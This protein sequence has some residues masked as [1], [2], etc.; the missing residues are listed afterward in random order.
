MKRTLAALGVVLAL[1]IGLSACNPRTAVNDA[2]AR[3]FPGTLT[4][5][6]TRVARCESGLNPRAVSRTNDHGLFQ[7]NYVHRRT[8][9]RLG[10]RWSQIYDPYVNSRVARH[11]YNQAGG[12]RPWS[13]RYA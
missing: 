5:K 8:V 13:C 12:W 6:A 1:T 9:E 11:I 2:I 3:H 10:Y 7:I 4:A